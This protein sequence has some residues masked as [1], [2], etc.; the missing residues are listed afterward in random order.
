VPVKE[1]STASTV[2]IPAARTVPARAPVERAGTVLHTVQAPEPLVAAG[3]AA[4]L[5]D[6][7]DADFAAVDLIVISGGIVFVA[8]LEHSRSISGR[9]DE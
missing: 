7:A 8:E 5:V 1:P 6:R 4:G 3:V 2:D 9:P